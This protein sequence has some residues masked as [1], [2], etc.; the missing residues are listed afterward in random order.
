[1]I[2]INGNLQPSTDQ[3]FWAGYPC[4]SYLPSTV[5]PIGLAGGLPV[6]IQIVGPRFA[7]ALVL[8]TGHALE[9]ALAW[10][11]WSPAAG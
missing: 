9:R 6:G 2:D 5:V 7:D 11:G 3:M 8:R 10:P 4:N 1:M